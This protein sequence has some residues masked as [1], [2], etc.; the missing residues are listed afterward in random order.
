MFGGGGH[1]NA[2][3]C[4]RE[5]PVRGSPPQ[6]RRRAYPRA[7]V[8]REM[9]SDP[10][11][12]DGVIVIQQAGRPDVARHRRGDAACLSSSSSIVRVHRRRRSTMDD[13]RSKKSATPGRSIRSPRA[14]CPW[15]SARRRG[16]RSFCRRPRRNTKPKSSWASATTTFDRGGEIVARDADAGGQRSDGRD[17]IEEAV[18][19]VPRHVSAA[20]AGLL[21]KENRRRPR[22]RSRAQERAR[23][24]GT[25]G[26]DGTAARRPRM[27][28]QLA[29]V[30]LV[31]SAGYYVRSLAD[32]I[33]ERL[34]TGAHLAAL[35]RTR[36]GDF[37]LA[38]AVGLD[39][40]RP[41][42]AGGSGAGD[43]AGRSAAVAAGR[44][45]DARRSFA[46]GARRLHR[47]RARQWRNQPFRLSKARASAAAPGRAPGGHRR[48]ARGRRRPDFHVMFCIRASYWNKIYS[49]GTNTLRRSW[50]APVSVLSLGR[51]R[52]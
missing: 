2:A 38:Q 27:A 31:C 3:G 28:G 10:L 42:P 15:S 49:F 39:V 46:G 36:S 32:A 47:P 44:H 13:R 7:H 18:A 23:T 16:S 5:R 48:A 4:T 41:A 43:S 19:G 11:F 26:G 25:G 6:D 14:C 33:G 9:G 8:K 21:R 30:R 24:A 1:K 51:S 22:L 20:A 35:V 37:T 40:A 17:S 52:R 29:S 50:G 12:T 34:G 45:A